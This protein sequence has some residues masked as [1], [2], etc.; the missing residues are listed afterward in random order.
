MAKKRAKKLTKKEL[1]KLPKFDG[2][3][4][5]DIKKLKKAIRQVWSW[6]YSRRLVVKRTDIGGG[7]SRCEKCKQKCPKIYVDHKTAIGTFDAKTYILRN[8]LPSRL[9]QG[10]CHEC[11]KT[12]TKA[13]NKVTASKKDKKDAD[14][15]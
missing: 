2:L 10:L 6:S 4:D 5:D 12:K 15:Y 7:Y 1:K 3:N 8:F 14:F 9:L 13:D 11:H